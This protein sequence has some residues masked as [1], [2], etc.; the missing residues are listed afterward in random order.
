MIPP[1]LAAF[2]EMIAKGCLLRNQGEIANTGRNFEGRMGFRLREKTVMR[3]HD[4]NDRSTRSRSHSPEQLV[5]VRILLP[6]FKT[7]R[8]VTRCRV[9]F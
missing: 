3:G 7:A 5:A 8:A 9:S 1:C 6:R 2:D 4:R